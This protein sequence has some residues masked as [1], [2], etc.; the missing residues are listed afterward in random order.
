DDDMPELQPGSRTIIA[1]QD[2]L[3]QARLSNGSQAQVRFKR[4]NESVET[5]RAA[6]RS[7]RPQLID[8]FDHLGQSI[9]VAP[10]IRVDYGLQVR[11]E[12]R[13]RLVR[14]QGLEAYRHLPNY[15]GEII[16]GA[17]SF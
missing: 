1:E 9:G 6:D 2:P 3:S 12:P 16:C 8:L 4:D 11:D 13:S 5:E 10:D 17:C 14:A 7:N 15:S